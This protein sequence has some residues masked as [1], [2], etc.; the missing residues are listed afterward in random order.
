MDTLFP[1]DSK[2]LSPPGRLVLSLFPG[3]GLLDRA[4]EDVGFC[5]VRGPDTLW[6]GDIR[7]FSPAGHFFGVIGG[8]PCQNFCTA[9]RKRDVAAGLVLVGEMFRVV[10]AAQPEFFLIEN[11]AGSPWFA[12][13]PGYALQAFTLDASQLGSEQRRLR[14]FHFG[15]RPGTPALVIKRDRSIVESQRTCLASEGKR[16]GRRT[17]KR[18]CELQGLPAGFDLP[19]F[20]VEQKYRAVGNGVPYLMARAL[21]D[22]IASRTHRSV[23]PFAL[24]ECGCGQ[25][26]KGRERT[27]SVACRKRLERERKRVTAPGVVTAEFHFCPATKE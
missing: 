24:C 13:F 25:Y 8:P 22:A 18:F 4:F 6:G 14:K 3:I 11:V 1:P 27:A 12:N 9:N 2:P 15:H 7:R 26:V 23:T 16:K 21:A 17:W 5:V 20:T 10:V 19:G